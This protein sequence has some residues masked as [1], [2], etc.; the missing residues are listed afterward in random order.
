MWYLIT[1]VMAF[2]PKNFW[3]RIKKKNK[4]NKKKPI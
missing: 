3:T 2:G 1:S 4:K